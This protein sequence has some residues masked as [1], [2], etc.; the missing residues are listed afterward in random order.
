LLTD[1]KQRV[2]GQF[3]LTT[4]GWEPYKTMFDRTIGKQASFAQLYK[5]YANPKDNEGGQRSYSP[6]QCI[7][8]RTVIRRGTPNKDL[9]STSFMERANL[10]VRLFNRRFTRLTLG[11]SKKFE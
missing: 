9:I 6:S 8:T 1:L 10:T 2:T 5:I 11:Y 3:Q 4:D 7:A